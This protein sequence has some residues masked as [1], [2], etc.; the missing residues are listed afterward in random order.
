MPKLES[1][2]GVGI[3]TNDLKKSKQFYTRTIGLK[4]RDE[5][6]KTGYIAL[7]ATKGGKDASLNLWQPVAAW[8][9]EMYEAGRKQIG[10]VTGIG[11]GTTDLKKTIEALKRKG[12]KARVDGESGTFGRFTDPDGNELFL[13]QP[14]RPKVH[15]AGLQNLAFTT[16][17]SRDVAKSGE[18]FTKA[19]GMK[20]L[21][22]PA[23]EGGGQSFTVYRLSSKGTAIMPFVPTKEMYDNPSDYDADMAHIGENTSIGFG[24]RD[25]YG[26][27]EALLA[28]GVRFSLKA[29]RRDWGGIMAR[30]LDPDDNMYA[31]MQHGR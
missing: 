23:S 29:E 7:G 16:V 27:Q 14:R 19:L 31:I 18:F 4:V 10:G 2:D 9:P 13:Q 30:I 28:K 3:Y 1:I 25:I 21:K 5:D 17:V 6:R 26:L 12:V 22:I 20:A 8:G 15:R 11:F 24:T